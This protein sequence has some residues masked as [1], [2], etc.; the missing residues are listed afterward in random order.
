[1]TFRFA[2]LRL[3]ISMHIDAIMPLV[4]AVEFLHYCLFPF[5]LSNSVCRVFGTE[6]VTNNENLVN[7]AT[8]TVTNTENPM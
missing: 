4:H 5:A 6:K 2:Q 8:N 3:T 1:M 7:F